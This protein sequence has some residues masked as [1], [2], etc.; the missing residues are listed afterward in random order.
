[1]PDPDR[2]VQTIH[3]ATQ[4]CCN[5]PGRRGRVIDLHDAVDVLVAGD[6]HGNLANFRWLLERADLRAFPRRHL[7]LQELI[8]GESRYPA[9]GEKSHQLVDLAAALKCQYPWRVHVLLGNHELAQWTERRIGKADQDL[10]ALFRQGVESAYG[11]R[12]AEIYAAY[13]QFFAALPLVVR[14]PNRVL[15]SHSLP[16][17]RRLQQFD[18]PRL[19]ADENEE[20]DLVPGGAIHAL[21]WGRDTA[22]ATAAEFLQ[23]MNADLLLTGH[24]ACERGFQVPNDRQIILD[25]LG[26]PAAF[27]LFPTDRPLTHQELVGCV[28]V[29]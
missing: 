26:A 25:S 2:L 8:H 3:R 23:R 15:I 17:A 12:A 24:I 11:D 7:V 14:T 1:M 13:K 20:R 4:A 5:A 16:S 27:C 10:N 21:V 19:E 6:L 18:P 9:G 22:P 29:L 28:G